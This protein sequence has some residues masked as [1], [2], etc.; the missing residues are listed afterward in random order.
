MSK[1]K[2]TKYCTAVQRIITEMSHLGVNTKKDKINDKDR[3][4]IARAVVEQI[5]NPTLSL[6]PER[7]NCARCCDR[8]CRCERDVEDKEIYDAAK[9]M[10]P[11]P[12]PAP[13]PSAM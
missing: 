4:I 7:S 10:V 3:F 12:P 2:R 8:S 5:K 6:I 1:D 13:A 11:P 9:K